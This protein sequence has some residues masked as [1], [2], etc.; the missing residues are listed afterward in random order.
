MEIIPIEIF[1]VAIDVPFTAPVSYRKA[2]FDDFGEKICDPNSGLG[3]RPDQIRL[4]R[5]DDLYD[6]EMTGR[7]FGDNG[8]LTR[9]S[10]RVKLSIRNA[11]NAAD[12]NIVKETLTRFYNL[13]EF[14][15]TTVTTLSTHVHARFPSLFERDEFLGSFSHNSDVIR[16]CALGYVRIADWEKDIR[17]LI[18]QSNLAPDSVFV[19]WDTQFTNTQDWDTFLTILPTMMEN[20]A[21]AFGL[22]FEPLRQP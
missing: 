8:S 6:Y 19:A 12:W 10:E 3:V 22:G 20:S 17:I 11:R 16:P 13:M 9:N 7:F 2:N 1:G 14:A 18:E 4:R 21:H 15:P 5:L